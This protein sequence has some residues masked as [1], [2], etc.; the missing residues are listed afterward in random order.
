MGKKGHK[1]HDNHHTTHHTHKPKATVGKVVATVASDIASPFGLGADFLVQRISAPNSAGPVAKSVV[2]MVA[3]KVTVDGEEKGSKAWRKAASELFSKWNPS[4]GKKFIMHLIK[5]CKK[6][7][8]MGNQL[9]SNSKEVKKLMKQSKKFNKV[10]IKFAFEF[11]F[12]SI[13][14][15]CSSQNMIDMAEMVFPRDL[16]LFDAFPRRPPRVMMLPRT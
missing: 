6:D 1:K 9:T 8:L 13:M 16:N 14:E 3:Q 2:E 7:G 15:D 11:F 4:V 5:F 10:E 12:I